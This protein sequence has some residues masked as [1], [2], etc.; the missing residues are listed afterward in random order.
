MKEINF[1]L[2]SQKAE[3][4]G[5][6]FVLGQRLVPFL[7]DIFS[8]VKEVKPLL[9]DINLSME[10]NMNK[11]QIAAKKLSKVTEA[12]EMATTE[13][14]DIINELVNKS[15]GI[16]TNLDRL[17]ELDSMKFD[18]ALNIL[19]KVHEAIAEKQDV[20]SYEVPLSDAIGKLKMIKRDTRKKLFDSTR[21]LL[22]GINADA[23]SIIMSLQVQDITSQQ[24]A[25]VN[26][27][28]DTI[29]ERLAHILMKFLPAEAR[30]SVQKDEISDNMTISKL[31]RPIAFNSEEEGSAYF[32]R[33]EID[34]LFFKISKHV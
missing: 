12:T 19:E 20:S 21:E 10:E 23:N 34:A 30:P 32:S 1:E 5:A 18:T 4:L 25:A 31:H 27:L 14:I 33:E 15:S 28:L 2:M 16:S 17:N 22:D 24:I 8:F 26:H 9:D 13:I 7:E 6:I 11:T 3:E 29:H